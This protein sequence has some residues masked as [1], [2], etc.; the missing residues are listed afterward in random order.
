MLCI[1]TVITMITIVAL[2]FEVC[3]E[4]SEMPALWSKRWGLVVLVGFQA[5]P[6]VKITILYYYTTKLL[7]T[8]ILHIVLLLLLFLYYNITTTIKVEGDLVRHNP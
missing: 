5:C 1:F 6:G 4:A 7:Y 3:F 2:T 8:A